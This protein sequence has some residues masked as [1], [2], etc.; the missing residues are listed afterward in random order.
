L[1]EKGRL[2]LLQ[3]SAYLPVLEPSV[4]PL[5]KAHGLDSFIIFI[6]NFLESLI[7]LRSYD[8]NLLLLLLQL[9]ADLTGNLLSQPE[10]P[11][12]DHTVLVSNPSVL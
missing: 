9:V 1:D 8:L 3:S 2:L 5:Y 11:H 10:V 6:K 12:I 7:H 4:N